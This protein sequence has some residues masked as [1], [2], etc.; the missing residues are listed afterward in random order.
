MSHIISE[1]G[2]SH[3][4]HLQIH[5]SLPALWYSGQTLWKFLLLPKARFMHECSITSNL[6]ATPWTVAHKVPLSK[7]FPK[8]EYWSAVVTKEGKGARPHFSS[9]WRASF[10]YSMGALQTSQ[11]AFLCILRPSSPIPVAIPTRSCC[12]FMVNL[13]EPRALF[14]PTQWLLFFFFSF[15]HILHHVES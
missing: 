10:W 1:P 14:L 11:I 6:F 4:S 5:P 7:G 3:Y 12:A 13:A 8:Q 9:V 2:S 15:C